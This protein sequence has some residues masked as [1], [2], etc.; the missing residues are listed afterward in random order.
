MSGAWPSA[1]PNLPA[2]APLGQ[3]LRVQT[4]TA[5]CVLEAKAILGEGPVWR[6]ETQDS[7]GLILFAVGAAVLLAALMYLRRAVATRAVTTGD[8][9]IAGGAG[10]TSTGSGV[11][12]NGQQK[13]GS[14][15]EV[16]AQNGGGSVLERPG[17]LWWLT[18]A[19]DSIKQTGFRWDCYQMRCALRGGAY[20]SRRHCSTKWQKMRRPSIPTAK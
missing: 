12:D 16:A 10:S 9:K 4:L 17:I 20:C 19:Q 11:R 6:A 15:G 7:L 18:R 1:T 8:E 3:A 13:T 14:N 5:E 2:S